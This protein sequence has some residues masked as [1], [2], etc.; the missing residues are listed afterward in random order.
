M[1]A[2][3]EKHICKLNVKSVN[4][5]HLVIIQSFHYTTLISL[6]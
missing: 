5:T 6:E 1:N 4:D 2:V 3:Y